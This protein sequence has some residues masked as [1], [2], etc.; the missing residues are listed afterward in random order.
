MMCRYK[1][2]SGMRHALRST[3]TLTESLRKRLDIYA[4][5][6][7]A[8]GVSLLPLASQPAEAEIIY[9]PA[10]Q[11][12][13]VNRSLNLDLNHDGI[14]DFQIWN[15]YSFRN[16][17]EAKLGVKPMAAV[18][19]IA[20]NSEYAAALAGGVPI[21]GSA[22]FPV[23]GDGI[24]V[25]WFYS[26]SSTVCCGSYGPWRNVKNRFLGLKFSING[27]IHYGWARLNVS[28]PRPKITATLTGYAYETIANKSIDA[29]QTKETAT[30]DL[31]PLQN[32][33]TQ[34]VS[35]LGVLAVGSVAQA[36]W[37]REET[38]VA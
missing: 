11:T 12:I 23:K 35:A 30:L 36:I 38:Y 7:S 15:K 1:G 20:G 22:R 32:R 6:A 37:R 31:R 16:A 2:V 33:R 3:K 13:G 4:L 9:T 19:R 24:M 26:F 25:W 27:E 29:G 21:G 18:N 17:I 14:A 8:T 34:Q 5:A 28:F 10:S